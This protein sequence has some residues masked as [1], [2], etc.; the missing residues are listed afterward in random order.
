MARTA[1]RAAVIAAM[2]AGLVL[3]GS[4]VDAASKASKAGSSHKARIRTSIRDMA[5]TPVTG[6][7]T[8]EFASRLVEQ[9]TGTGIAGKTVFVRATDVLGAESLV[10]IAV[11][12]AAGLA[13]CHP[14]YTP[15]A[16]EAVEAEASRLTFSFEGDAAYAPTSSYMCGLA[17]TAVHP[18]LPE[19]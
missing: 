15:G 19:G 14:G 6:V 5:M 18:C 16:V 17:F 13:V 8:S 9:A 10:C 1:G 3:G 2:V 4:P 11:S 7:A 12:D